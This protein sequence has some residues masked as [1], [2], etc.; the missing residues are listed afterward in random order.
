MDFDVDIVSATQETIKD[1]E[2]I[3]SARFLNDFVISQ[4]ESVELQGRRQFYHLRLWWSLAIILWISIIMLFHIFLT[5]MIGLNTWSFLSSQN[6]LYGIIIENFLQIVGM[7]YIIVKF[8][9]PKE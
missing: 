2:E 1:K 3:E 4:K 8:L 9:Y 6:F 7:A 5:A